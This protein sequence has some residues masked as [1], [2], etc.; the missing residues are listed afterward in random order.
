MWPGS[1]NINSFNWLLL[2]HSKSRMENSNL[3][4]QW[5]RISGLLPDFFFFNVYCH[6][7]PSKSLTF[8]S[9]I[10]CE[11]L[12]PYIENLDRPIRKYYCL[13]IGWG[14]QFSSW[15]PKEIVHF[16]GVQSSENVCFKT[17]NKLML[18]HTRGICKW[19]TNNTD[20]VPPLIKFMYKVTC[21]Q[22]AGALDNITTIHNDCQNI[23]HIRYAEPSK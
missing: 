5:P 18:V 6:A 14:K 19:F 15:T 22:R 17:N 11:H 21:Q 8:F 3:P 12:G 23:A 16:Y 4:W 1:F 7:N 10:E 13:S 20:Q 9:L 2:F